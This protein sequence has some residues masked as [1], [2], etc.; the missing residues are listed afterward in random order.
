MAVG[1]YRGY[2][3]TASN[4]EAQLTVQILTEPDG[5]H[6]DLVLIATGLAPRDFV[7]IAASGLPSSVPNTPA[8]P[9]TSEC[10]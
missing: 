3:S 7:R 4:R 2:L 8:Q 1:A 9:C 10:G 5:S 6:H